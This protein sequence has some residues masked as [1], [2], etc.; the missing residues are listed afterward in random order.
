MFKAQISIPSTI[1]EVMKGR[2]KRRREGRKEG[3]RERG[4][5]GRKKLSFWQNKE[6]GI[7]THSTSS[8]LPVTLNYPVFTMQ[9]Y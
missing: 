3:G 2:R 5:E 7:H 8:Q 6:F 9:P 1:R 4:K